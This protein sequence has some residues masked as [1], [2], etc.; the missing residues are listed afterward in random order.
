MSRTTVVNVKTAPRGSYLY[1]G[2]KSYIYGLPESVWHNPFH[3][4]RDGPPEVVVEKFLR[5]HLMRRPDLVARL[6]E[7]R[8]QVLGCWCCDWDGSGEPAR[9][10][11]AV[12]LARLADGPRGD[13]PAG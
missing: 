5:L 13:P 3:K 2:R 1:V 7:L 12:E 11:H 9:P 6:H 10:C 8:G 4:G